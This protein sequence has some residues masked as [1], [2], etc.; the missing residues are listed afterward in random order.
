MPVHLFIPELRRILSALLPEPLTGPAPQDLPDGFHAEITTPRSSSAYVR[1][2]SRPGRATALKGSPG[3][4]PRTFVWTRDSCPQ[5]PLPIATSGSLTSGPPE[6]QPLPEESEMCCTQE[7]M[8]AL[9][10]KR[11]IFLLDSRD[12]YLQLL[13]SAENCFTTILQIQRQKLALLID[14]IFNGLI[15]KVTLQNAVAD[16]IYLTG[17]RALSNCPQLWLIKPRI[18]QGILFNFLQIFANPLHLVAI[19]SCFSPLEVA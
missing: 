4:L 18:L 10:E 14:S 6:P 16:L 1:G 11:A 3:R 13:A 5:S 17:R 8:G 7:L 15:P 12:R 2:S 19:R 9:K